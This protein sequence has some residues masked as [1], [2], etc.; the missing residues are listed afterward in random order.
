LIFNVRKKKHASVKKQ[1]KHVSA[2]KQK[3]HFNV[4]KS[5]R[6]KQKK[7]VR[8]NVRFNARK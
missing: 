2:K 6:I 7:Q 5:I 8:F 1:K 4:K 3:K